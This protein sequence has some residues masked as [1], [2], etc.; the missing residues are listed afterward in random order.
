MAPTTKCVSFIR[1]P[2]ALVQIA[3][4][5]WI[6]QVHEPRVISKLSSSF[7]LGSGP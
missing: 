3:R 4:I 1:R 7:V 5:S 2:P 6:N